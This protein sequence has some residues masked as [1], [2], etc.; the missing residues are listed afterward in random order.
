M[1]G[2]AICTGIILIVCSVLAYIYSGRVTRRN[3]SFWKVLV[4]YVLITLLAAVATRYFQREV[5]GAKAIIAL[6]K[7]SASLPTV[8]FALKGHQLRP[9]RF[10]RYILLAI[11]FGMIGDIAININPVAGGALFLVGHLLYD[12]A[13]LSERKPS[14]KQVELW[15]AMSA[16]LIIPMYV[17][18]AK[19]GS[20][21]YCIGGWVY[22]SILISTVVFS[23]SLQ[24]MVFAAALIFAFSDCFMIANTFGDGSMLMKVLALEVYYCSLLLYG[25]V[26]WNR[27]YH[28]AELTSIEVESKTV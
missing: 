23:R 28:S 9:A 14:A 18:R 8:L 25:A 4:L 19:I 21:V 10:S 7:F 1:T 13:F 5:H 2:S 27:N 20:P 16:L 12:G 3:E 24:K 22:L 11:G 6:L 17:F 15:L 26:L